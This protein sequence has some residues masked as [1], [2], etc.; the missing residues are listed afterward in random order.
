MSIMHFV[1]ICSGFTAIVNPSKT[2]ELLCTNHFYSNMFLS[3]FSD[4]RRVELRRDESTVKTVE[5][6]NTLIHTIN[7]TAERN[8]SRYQCVAILA[9]G[10]LD[11]MDAGQL[12]LLG[13]RVQ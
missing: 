5:G 12:Y 1:E 9:N 8:G 11:R 6:C 10:T 3:N 4:A 13:K 7:S 2:Q